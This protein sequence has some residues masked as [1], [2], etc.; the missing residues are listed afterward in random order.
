MKAP[1]PD[2]DITQIGAAEAAVLPCVAAYT[3][4]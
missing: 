2:M 4:G 3:P 1:A